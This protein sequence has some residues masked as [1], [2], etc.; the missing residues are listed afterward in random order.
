M[1]NLTDEQKAK[2]LEFAKEGKPSWERY[3]QMSR[4]LGKDKVK[5]LTIKGLRKIVQDGWEHPLYE[6]RGAENIELPSGYALHFLGHGMVSLHDA[7]VLLFREIYNQTIDGQV[8]L[9][10]NT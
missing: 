8:F 6:I 4:A 2:V 3:D 10:E 5:A 1:I 7:G 9:K